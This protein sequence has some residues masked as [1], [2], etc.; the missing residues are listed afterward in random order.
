MGVVYDKMPALSIAGFPYHTFFVWK[1]IAFAI[2]VRAYSSP[3]AT[4]TALMAKV[5]LRPMAM[6]GITQ[7]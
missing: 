6:P 4:L 2:A 3:K 1:T 7:G 5:M